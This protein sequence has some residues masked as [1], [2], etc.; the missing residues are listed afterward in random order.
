[1]I[2]RR[3]QLDAFVSSGKNHLARRVV[4]FLRD[5]YP[6]AAAVPDTELLGPVRRLMR[7]AEFYG[8]RTEQ[9]IAIYVIAGFLL[10]ESFDVDFPA[11][12]QILPSPVISPAEKT[13]WLLEW[14]TQLFRALES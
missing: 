6:D 10:G 8:L 1:M 4:A 3:Q 13:S 9:D 14:T 12:Q 11:A 7:R 5:Q 2:I